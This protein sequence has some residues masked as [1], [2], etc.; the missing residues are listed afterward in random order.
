M[1]AFQAEVWTVEVAFA[2]RKLERCYREFAAGARAWG[3]TVA[4]KYVQRIDIMQEASDLAE[5]EVLP[6]LECHPLKGRR[7]GQFAL[8]LHDR[9][10]LVFSLSGIEVKIIRIEE[11]SKH[12]GD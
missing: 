10:R 4:R 8:I 9:W 6:G 2:T 1:N 12:Y 11:V 7:K 3:Q 5:L